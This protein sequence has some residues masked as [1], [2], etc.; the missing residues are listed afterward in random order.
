MGLDVG[1]VGQ[2]TLGKLLCTVLGAGAGAERHRAKPVGPAGEVSCDGRVGLS[3]SL[4]RC[5]AGDH[6]RPAERGVV[7][8]S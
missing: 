4:Q 3:R 8:A 6:N 1:G 7:A 2:L 5:V